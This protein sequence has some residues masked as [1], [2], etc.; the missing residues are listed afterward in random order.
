MALGI[1]AVEVV[2]RYTEKVREVEVEAGSPDA[3]RAVVAS[4]GEITGPARLVRVVTT[5]KPPIDPAPIDGPAPKVQ[6]I[7]QTGKQFKAMML[8]FGGLMLVGGVSC[9][10][11]IAAGPESGATVLGGMLFVVGLLGWVCAS[12]AAWWHHG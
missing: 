6:T 4:L 10:I 11:G 12:V 9:S 8:I 7:E 5:P 3:A 1:Y 2:D